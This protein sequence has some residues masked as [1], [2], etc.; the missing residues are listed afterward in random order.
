[1]LLI[2]NEHA[3]QAYVEIDYFLDT[4]SLVLQSISAGHR[5]FLMPLTFFN[6]KTVVQR[7]LS[8]EIFKTFLLLAFEIR[9]LFSLLSFIVTRRFYLLKLYFASNNRFYICYMPLY[10]LIS[11]FCYWLHEADSYHTYITFLQ[12]IWLKIFYQNCYL[13]KWWILPSS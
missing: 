1:M 10:T 9:L 11:S 8:F 7:L 2:D 3:W 12:Q 13:G 6:F 4:M 5:Q